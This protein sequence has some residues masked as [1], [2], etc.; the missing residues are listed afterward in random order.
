MALKVLMLRKRLTEKQEA[1]AQLRTAAEGFATREADLERAIDEAK[2]DEEKAAVEA[3]VEQYDKDKDENG[4]AAGKLE[5]EIAD[6]ERELGELEQPAPIASPA[7]GEE[8]AGRKEKMNTME[9]RSF[10]AMSMEQRSAFVK[11]EGV[12][13]FLEQVRGLVTAG[14]NRRGITGTELTIPEEVLPLLTDTTERYSKLMKHVNLKPVNGT[15]RVNVL[16]VIPEAVWTEQGGKIN[17]LAFGFT[18]SEIDGFK[19]AGYFAL[20]TW[21]IEDSDENLMGII[22]DTLGQSIGLAVDKAILYGTGAKMPMGIVTR[23][24]QTAAPSVGTAHADAVDWKDLHTSNITSIA[25]ANTGVKLFQALLKASGAAKSNYSNGAK[26]WAM[27]DATLN[28]LKAEAMSVNAAGAIVTGMGGEMPIIGGPVETLSF[29]P[30][31]VIIGGY[32][33]LYLL[34]QRSGAAIAA[35][36]HVRFLEDQTVAKGVARYDG[37]PVIP[38]GF[39]AI[40]ISGT[41]VKADAVTFAAD[42]ANTPPVEAGS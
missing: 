2:T 14:A 11:R 33:S 16:G 8:R 22:V 20:P 10:K 39:I 4:A 42:A 15:E 32:G 26:F 13:S 30:D 36:E 38:A 25:A 37:M 24:A 35:S 3:A 7:A 18:G 34:G 27:N 23:L 31:N 41:T 19:V 12:K 40:G 6:I 5:G 21:V 17:E 29:I 9:N 28:A 1:L